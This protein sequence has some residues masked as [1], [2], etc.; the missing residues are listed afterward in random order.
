[1]HKNA[2]KFE[3]LG[4]RGQYYHKIRLKTGDFSAIFGQIGGEFGDIL[5]LNWRFLTKKFWQHWPAA[6]SF[7]RLL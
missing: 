3:I 6:T 5:D 7:R 4:V 2:I 1:M